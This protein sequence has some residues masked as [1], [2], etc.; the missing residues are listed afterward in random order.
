MTVT[1]AQTYRCLGCAGDHLKGEA[2]PVDVER[3]RRINAFHAYRP[4]FQDPANARFV[5][6]QTPDNF[7]EEWLQK[8]P[9]LKAIYL[10]T[11]PYAPLKQERAQA[12]AMAAE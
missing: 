1:A 2:C 6:M 9:T 4:D 3:I 10:A 8:H 12:S 7:F 11:G 5:M